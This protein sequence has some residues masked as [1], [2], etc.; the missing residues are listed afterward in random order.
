MAEAMG[1]GTACLGRAVVTVIGI[2][3]GNRA[4]GESLPMV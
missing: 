3:I 1:M 2:G 4:D